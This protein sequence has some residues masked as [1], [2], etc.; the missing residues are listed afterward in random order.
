MITAYFEIDRINTAMPKDVKKALDEIGR[1]MCWGNDSK[2]DL[3]I[4]DILND[5]DCEPYFM[6]FAKWIKEQNT[7]N[8]PVLINYWW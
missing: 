7:E 5:V 4:E 2:H 6:T 8:H 3:D 1:H